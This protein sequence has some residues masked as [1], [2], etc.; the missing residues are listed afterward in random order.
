MAP[1]NTAG[2]V[3][4]SITLTCLSNTGDVVWNFSPINTIFP[5]TIVAGCEVVTAASD[6][7]RV[8]T[9]QE[10]CHLV[11]DR[12]TLDHAGWYT[13]EDFVTGDKPTSA[14]LVVLGSYHK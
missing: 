10:A 1:L 11:I 14:Q 2:V 3:G 5:V 6:M 9:Q 7:F 13:C 4:Q 12:L 8:D